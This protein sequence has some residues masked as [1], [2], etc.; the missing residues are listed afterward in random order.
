MPEPVNQDWGIIVHLPSG[1]GV[2]KLYWVDLNVGWK[3]A[4]L[5]LDIRA[6]R[7]LSR[8]ALVPFVVQAT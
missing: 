6:M 1:E 2:C 5:A 4:Q 7:S 3:A 8:K